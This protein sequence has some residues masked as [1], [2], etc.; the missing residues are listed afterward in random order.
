MPPKAAIMKDN[1]LTYTFRVH[2]NGTMVAQRSDKKMPAVIFHAGEC[3]EFC[4]IYDEVEFR[5]VKMRQLNR[6]Q[7]VLTDHHFIFVDHPG[8]VRSFAI[9]PNVSERA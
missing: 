8:L 6:P 4:R 7:L 5:R 9:L 2:D 3:G 1:R